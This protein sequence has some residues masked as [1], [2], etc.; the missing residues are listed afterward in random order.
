MGWIPLDEVEP[1]RCVAVASVYERD[2]KLLEYFHGLGLRPGVQVLLKSRNYD[3]TFTLG[4]AGTTVPLGRQAAA[5]IWVRSIED[6]GQALR[7]AALP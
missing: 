1:G 6:A 7:T 2:R 4:V 3:E 5:R